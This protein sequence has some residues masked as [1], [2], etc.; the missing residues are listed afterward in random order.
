MSVKDKYHRKIPKGMFGRALFKIHQ[1]PVARYY[2][3]HEPQWANLTPCDTAGRRVLNQEVFPVC[4]TWLDKRLRIDEEA[5]D[6]TRRKKLMAVLLDKASIV[7]C[8][9][10]LK[11]P[12]FLLG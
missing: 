2:F 10:K 1:M 6:E 4:L 5:L 8:H 3:K 11:V 7:D 12:A 9:D